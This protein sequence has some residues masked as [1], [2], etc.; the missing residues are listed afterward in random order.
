MKSWKIGEGRGGKRE[1]GGRESRERMR[2]AK[3]GKR[4][5]RG[6]VAND[7][8]MS[9]LTCARGVGETK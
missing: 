2:G 3:E 1:T 6:R 9:N 4:G 8:K 5:K 7:V